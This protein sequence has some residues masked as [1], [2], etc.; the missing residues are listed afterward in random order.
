[1]NTYEYTTAFT[2]DL[3]TAPWIWL[4]LNLISYAV[5]C[6]VEMIT[7]QCFDY[8]GIVSISM[9][10]V[11]TINRLTALYSLQSC[12]IDLYTEV[13]RW[14]FDTDW[15]ILSIILCTNNVQFWDKIFKGIRQYEP[16]K[17]LTFSYLKMNHEL[18]NII[19]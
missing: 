1:M 16:G 7:Y 10:W 15:N 4:S 13:M 14:L 19:F 9:S 3:R 6:K 11:V 18:S 12:F 8:E 5:C 2:R 17:M